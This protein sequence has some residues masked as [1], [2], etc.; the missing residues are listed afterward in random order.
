[1]TTGRIN[2]VHASP[3]DYSALATITCSQVSGCKPRGTSP[4]TRPNIQQRDAVRNAARNQDLHNWHQRSRSPKTQKMCW[5]SIRDTGP[6]CSACSALQSILSIT[7]IAMRHH[8]LKSPLQTIAVVQP[9]TYAH[10]VVVTWRASDLQWQATLLLTPANQ[11]TGPPGSLE[12][13]V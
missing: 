12:D 6:A 7:L 4:E 1:M 5:E 3:R 9:R 8:P 13:E 2:Q 10:F 11:G